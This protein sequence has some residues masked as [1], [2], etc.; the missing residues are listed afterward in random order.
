MGQRGRPAHKPSTHPPSHLQT[1][2]GFSGTN[3]SRETFEREVRTLIE[4]AGQRAPREKILAA[5]QAC[6]KGYQP[7]EGTETEKSDTVLS[8]LRPYP[9]TESGGG[10]LTPEQSI[11]SD[12]AITG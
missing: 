4:L 6:V 1:W 10:S 7:P 3:G 2:R 5:L 8:T 9:D 11:T 12:P